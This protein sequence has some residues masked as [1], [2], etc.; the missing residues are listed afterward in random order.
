MTSPSFMAVQ[1]GPR[2]ISFMTTD[3][4]DTRL[5]RTQMHKLD[6]R[7]RLYLFL[8]TPAHLYCWL[9]SR[10]FGIGWTGPYDDHPNDAGATS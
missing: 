4:A 9:L 1:V 6:F 2:K 5:W 3:G 8:L 7:S 10:L